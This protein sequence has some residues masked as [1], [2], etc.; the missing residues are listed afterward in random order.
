MMPRGPTLY[1]ILEGHKPVPIGDPMEW[2]RFMANDA[3]RRVALTV[4]QQPGHDRVE[5]ST[6]FIG[7]NSQFAQDGEPRL[8]ESMVFGG[9]L[10]GEMYRYPTWAEAEA[11]HAILAEEAAIEG[12]VVAWQV[13]EKLK[14]LCRMLP[15]NESE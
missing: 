15:A 13:R 6:V 7:L 9:P 3:L 12:E 10:H 8:F 14:A 11:G 5:V 1:W 2:A 4:I